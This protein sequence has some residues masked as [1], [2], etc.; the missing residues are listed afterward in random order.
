M[1]TTSRTNYQELERRIDALE[2]RIDRLFDKAN[3]LLDSVLGLPD[4]P[5]SEGTV[6]AEGAQ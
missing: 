2:E 3:R 6:E 5:G 1:D 4:T